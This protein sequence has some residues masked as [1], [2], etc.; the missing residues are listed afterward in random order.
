M[1]NPN[2]LLWS[3]TYKD[4]LHHL[5][6]HICIEATHNKPAS[7]HR[8]INCSKRLCKAFILR[9]LLHQVIQ[10]LNVVLW[11]HFQWCCADTRSL[12][13]YPCTRNTSYNFLQARSPDQGHTLTS[14][15]NLKD[16][17]YTKLCNLFRT[18]LDIISCSDL[19]AVSSTSL[20]SVYEFTPSR[21]PSVCF[22]DMIARLFMSKCIHNWYA[23]KLLDILQHLTIQTK[24]HCVYFW[25]A[26]GRKQFDVL[27]FK[28]TL[29]CTDRL[30]FFA[31]PS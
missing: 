12:I 6:V 26:E 1:L 14:Y 20:S 24:L 18:S 23:S 13:F 17:H 11:K 10:Y 2:P 31:C 15:I 25:S 16:L 19:F 27:L 28:L 30:Q 29:F 21:L 4:S 3:I 9:C 5:T 7:R 8:Q 22:F